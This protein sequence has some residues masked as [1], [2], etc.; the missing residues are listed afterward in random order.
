M[1]PR[2]SYFEWRPST[3]GKE[4]TQQ[5]WLRDRDLLL[6]SYEQDPGNARTLFYLAQTYDCLG[7]WH[8]AFLFYQKRAEIRGWDEEDF[9]TRLRLGNVCWE[10]TRDEEPTLCPLPVWYYL[11]AFSLRPHRA[12][13]LVSIARYYLKKGQMHLAFVFAARAIQIPYPEHD[14]LFVEKYL[15]DVVRYDLLGRCAWYVGEYELGRMGGDGSFKSR[16][17]CIASAL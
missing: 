16:S 1:V 7:D 5:R 17:R 8:N 15:Y 14:I 4:K 10:L 11:E 3:V 2:D 13:P 12:E 9:I 6:K